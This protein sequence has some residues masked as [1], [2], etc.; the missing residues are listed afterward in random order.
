[1]S[2]RAWGV[3]AVF[4]VA[5]AAVAVWKYGERGIEGSAGETDADRR[6]EIAEFWAAYHEATRLRVALD[7]E[8]AIRA[9]REAVKRRPNHEES[10][11]YL[12][13]CLFEL[14]DYSAALD[15]YQ[16]LVEVNRESLR[17]YSQL[18]VVL[19]T[20]APGGRP[21]PAAAKAALLRSLELDPEDTGTYL[22]L[23]LL[24]IRA[25]LLDDALD[26]FSKA[27][28]SASAQG[29]FRSGYVHLL[30][31]RTAAAREHFAKVLEIAEMER[32]LS[33]R[34]A[35]VEGDTRHREGAAQRRGESP[36]PAPAAQPAGPAA[37]VPGGGAA[38]PP[39]APAKTNWAPLREAA[40][41][42]RFLLDRLAA[43][44]PPLDATGRLPDAPRWLQ[45]LPAADN[46]SLR[47]EPA[48]RV[49]PAAEA[50]SWVDLDGDGSPDLV[51]RRQRELWWAANRGG[52]LQLPVLLGESPSDLRVLIWSDLDADGQPDALAYGGSPSGSSVIRLR[53]SGSPA[54]G[55]RLERAPLPPGLE[56]SRVVLDALLV[57]LDGDG[58]EDLVEGGVGGPTDPAARLW[59]RRG[60]RFEAL[61]LIGT[62]PNLSLGTVPNS[63]NAPEGTVP[64]APNAP[65]GT[66]PKVLAGDLDGDGR[67]DVLL[68]R[69]RRPP[70]VLW[71]EGGARFALAPLAGVPA[72][73]LEAPAAALLDFDGDERL[74]VVVGRRAGYAPAVAGLLDGEPA[75]PAQTLLWLRNEGERRFRDVSE[76]MAAGLGFGVLDLEAADV[77]GDD[78]PDLLVLAGD[79]APGAARLE[80]GRVLLNRGGG[81][82]EPDTL[83]PPVVSS[84]SGPS[85]ALGPAHQRGRR[86]LF[87][88]GT[89][90]V[91]LS[92]RSAA[93]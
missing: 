38:V 13:N 33:N 90:A 61:G 91:V 53:A 79:L 31:G 50:G 92:P 14:G 3:P 81:S 52:R 37:P 51:F 65:E 88:P 86:L 10:W 29:V 75:P 57:D 34:G 26:H 48:S 20:W 8:S 87:V 25:G 73:T 22:R 6:R 58:R 74:D 35:R 64:N 1:M 66:V 56:G 18:G 2:R 71:N 17:G 9:Y 11:Y 85:L 60:N 5:F 49:E 4:A 30:K 42:S 12:G 69:W 21:D 93:R 47:L 76:G 19:A 82:F 59:L 23:G 45:G 16:R 41:L 63:P 62:V 46:A 70:V 15:A 80:P 24:E 27:A 28:G 55:I 40:L 68:L 39:P 32:R 84:G 43:A 44:V 77:D 72:G 36:A 54:E 89:G 78:L 83:L 7:Y 67:V